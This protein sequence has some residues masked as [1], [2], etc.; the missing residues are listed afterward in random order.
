M[1]WAS[2]ARRPNIDATNTISASIQQP[3]LQQELRHI[4]LDITNGTTTP[5]W[6]QVLL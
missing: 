4:A 6:L 5:A 2:F 1:N 3:A